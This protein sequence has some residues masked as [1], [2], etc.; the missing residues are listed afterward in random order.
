MYNSSSAD[1]ELLC[2]QFRNALVY[3]SVCLSVVGARAF[4]A[5]Y[6]VDNVSSEVGGGVLVRMSRK[7]VPLECDIRISRQDAV[8]R[9]LFSYR[10]YLQ[11]AVKNPNIYEWRC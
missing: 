1:E 8:G 11:R 6:F 4:V 5:G 10:I 7:F 9:W 2:S 3:K